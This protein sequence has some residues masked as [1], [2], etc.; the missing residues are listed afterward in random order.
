[1]FLDRLRLTTL[2]PWAALCCAAAGLCAPTASLAQAAA[3][4]SAPPADL[5][6]AERAQRD[7]DKVY[8][9]IMIHSD[10]PRKAAAPA[11]DEKPVAVVARPKPAARS[12]EA[13]AANAPSS[14]GVPAAGAV[15]AAPRLA[16]AQS[17]TSNADAPPAG[18]GAAPLASGAPRPGAESSA[19]PV[20]SPA[21]AQQTAAEIAAEA[22]DETLTP[23]VRADPQF[24]PNLLRTLRK[25]QV[26][27]RFTVL[28]DGSVAEPTVVSTSNARLNQ[29]AMTAVAQWRFAPLRKS[30]SGVV[31]LGFNLD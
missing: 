2:G 6:A 15:D 17:A 3:A 30:Q 24:P 14:P 1:M 23:I 5:T 20:G 21:P 11:R 4:A 18:A 27:V 7:A 13:A 10:K 22:L 26:Q 31:D 16:A 25:G 8:H 29:A 12:G 28:P 19:I 9:W